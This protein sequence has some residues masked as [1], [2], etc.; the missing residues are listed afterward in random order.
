MNDLADGINLMTLNDTVDDFLN[1]D[2]EQDINDCLYEEFF[3]DTNY[4]LDD[5]EQDEG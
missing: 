5:D 2:D 1:Y 4:S 3:S